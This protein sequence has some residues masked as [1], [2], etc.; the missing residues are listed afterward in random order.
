[1]Q[2]RVE[3]CLVVRVTGG[4]VWVDLGGQLVPCALRGR[5][6]RGDGTRVVA[7][8]RV[9][10]TLPAREGETGAIEAVEKRASL[11]SRYVDRAESERPIVANVDEL[12]VVATLT[13]P[14]LRHA[15]VDRLLASAERGGVSSAVVLNKVDLC[16]AG[17]VAA[18]AAVYTACG[19]PVLATS[20]RTGEGSEALAR[21]LGGGVY[22]FA[23]ASGVGKSS[24]LM[25]LDP[26]LDL[27]TRELGERTG[28]GR[29][30]TTFS[31]L[32]RFSGGWLADTPGAQTF[33][34]PGR[35]AL[36]LVRC[37][38]EFAGPGGD[39]RF[40][41]C[42]H[43]HEPG[44]GVKAAVERGKVPVTR[45]ESFLQI[46]GEIEERRRRRAR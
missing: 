40:S 35:E 20:A 1:M 30:T 41:P 14:P 29:H 13:S 6:R 7:G 8:D 34:F 15:F 21:R 39:C 44:C 22:A 5:M 32:Y 23:G 37:F 3:K 27:K 28:R 25:R 19:Y 2:D 42:T 10:V 18:F 12:F 9:T 24:L 26:R 11:L 36:E 17:E 38:P 33:G 16:D 4:E 46:L 45:H 43:S 31:Q